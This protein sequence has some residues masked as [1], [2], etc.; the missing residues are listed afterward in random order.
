M[1]KLLI[2]IIC[3]LFCSAGC[4]RIT[5][6]EDEFTY[7]RLGKQSIDGLVVEKDKSGVLKV[8]IG[9]QVGSSGVMAKILTDIAKVSAGATGMELI[10]H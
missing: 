6:K 5:W 3:L 1:K 9:K 2:L 4:A 7:S 8:K 10:A